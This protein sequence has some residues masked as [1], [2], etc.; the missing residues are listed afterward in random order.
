ML[1][2]PLKLSWELIPFQ[3]PRLRRLLRVKKRRDRRLLHKLKM[4]NWSNDEKHSNL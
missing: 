4:E 3:F 1:I 2:H